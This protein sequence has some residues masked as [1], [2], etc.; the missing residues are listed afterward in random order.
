MREL[1]WKMCRKG[2]KMRSWLRI[3]ELVSVTMSFFHPPVL[4]LLP[5]YGW[6]L[7][8]A[9][10]VAVLAWIQLRHHVYAWLKRRQNL[11][12]EQNFGRLGSV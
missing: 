2:V 10:V 12:E 4:Q 8:L 6:Y 3:T 5:E 11:L 1:E 9:L 7:L